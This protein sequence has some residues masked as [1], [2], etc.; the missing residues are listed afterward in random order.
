MVEILDCP[1]AKFQLMVL[2]NIFTLKFS[3]SMETKISLLNILCY[4]RGF[5]ILIT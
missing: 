2:I 4:V 3:L 5:Y 1:E